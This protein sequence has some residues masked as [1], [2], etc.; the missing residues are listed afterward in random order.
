LAHQL[1]RLGLLVQQ[2]GDGLE[3]GIEVD[4]LAKELQVGEAELG[5]GGSHDF[6]IR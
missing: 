6:S 2:V 3:G 4:A 1:D 5:A